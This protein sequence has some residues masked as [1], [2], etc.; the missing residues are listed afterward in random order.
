MNIP[1]KII[2]VFSCI[3]IIISCLVFP[4]S[5]SGGVSGAVQTFLEW[6][7]KSGEDVVNGFWKVIYGDDWRSADREQLQSA[8]T[9]YVTDLETDLGTATL[10]DG[11]VRIFYTP[12][13]VE[14]N[15]NYSTSVVHSLSSNFSAHWRQI[16]TVYSSFKFV[17]NDSV[18]LPFDCTY[19]AGF[20]A[21]C[22][23]VTAQ[24]DQMLSSGSGKKGYGILLSSNTPKIV[25]S[26]TSYDV[27]CAVS[28]FAYLDVYPSSDLSSITTQDITINSRP[29]SITGDYG[30]IGDN[31]IITKV[32]G[33]VIVDESASTIYNPI[34][35]T[36]TNF[37]NWSYD[38]SDRSY[39][40]TTESGDTI[41]VTYG[42]ENISINE[43][44]TVYNVYYVIPQDEQQP[45]DPGTDSGTD[46]TH[47]YTDEITKQPT[48]LLS[49]VRTYTCSCGD[50]YT[51]TV[52]ATGHDWQISQQVPNT[53]DPETG[54]QT[55]TGYTV[56]TCATC[57]EQYKSTDG[58]APPNGNSS[59]G[60]S[61]GLGDILSGLLAVLGEIL[62]ALVG[63]FLTLVTKALEALSGM[64]DFFIQFFEIIP[65]FFGSFID[66]LAAMFPFLPEE[67][68]TILNF[69]LI[70]LIAAAIF[71]KFL[72]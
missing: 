20:I 23:N 41:T 21:S 32:D 35:N 55:Q 3:A 27:D 46:H 58:Q 8:Y 67:T 28:G 53:Y 33:N 57:G 29:T 24:S 2:A 11:G 9:T 68:I 63:F 56:Y 47:T 40:L 6:S 51:K 18:V 37:T 50:S 4:V 34:T 5:A 25:L 17:F 48:C 38:Y 13:D 30:I 7:V 10:I 39:N 19:Q 15:I 12:S 45:S 52:P 65:T 22:T 26:P 31:G 36:T 64:L 66:F 44:D 14:Y 43:G 61:I 72:K 42:D 60:S 71:R 62:G 54:E 69:G 1:K 49:G 16:N 70:L 59:G